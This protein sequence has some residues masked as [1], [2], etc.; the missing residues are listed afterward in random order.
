VYDPTNL[1]KLPV[2]G[3]QAGPV[4]DAFAKFDQAATADGAIPKKYKEMIAVAVA[5]ATQ[6]PYCIDIHFK[7]ARKAGA[8]D[9][10]LTETAFVSAAIKAA[11]RPLM[12]RIS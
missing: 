2:L 9:E 4:W 11:E 12:P 5:L 6:C 10:E 8:T 7:S 1:R 3:A